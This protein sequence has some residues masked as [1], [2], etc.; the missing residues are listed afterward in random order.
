MGSSSQGP[1]GVCGACGCVRAG[2]GG[3]G[4]SVSSGDLAVVTRGVL[5]VEELCCLLAE[6]AFGG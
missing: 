6:S 2:R 1:A 4:P 3:C 5:R